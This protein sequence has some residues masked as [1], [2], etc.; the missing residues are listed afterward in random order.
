M[1]GIT[2][3]NTVPGSAIAE[4]I[5]RLEPLVEEYPRTHV[6]IACLTLAVLGQ[7]TDIS[8]DEL[9]SIVRGASQYICTELEMLEFKMEATGDIPK[10]LVN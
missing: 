6:I 2:V 5:E 10:N 4:I 3:T 7:N 8:P 1:S 9:Q